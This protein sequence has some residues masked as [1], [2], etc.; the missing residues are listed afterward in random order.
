[1]VP[2]HVE[3]RVVYQFHLLRNELSLAGGFSPVF[4]CVVPVLGRKAM[5]KMLSIRTST[6]WPGCGMFLM[7]AVTGR[8]VY[9]RHLAY[10][11]HMF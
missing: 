1:M 5:E 9:R 8:W 3:Q 2:G 11:F 7:K 10:C 6:S 4:K